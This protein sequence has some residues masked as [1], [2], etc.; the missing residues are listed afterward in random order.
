MMPSPGGTTSDC[1]Y[2]RFSGDAVSSLSSGDLQG[3]VMIRR[4]MCPSRGFAFL[5]VVLSLVLVPLGGTA[6]SQT[7]PSIKLTS[8]PN[9]VGSGARALGMGGAFIAVADDA[10]AAS[11]NPGGLPQLERPEISVVG[12]GYHRIE[13]NTFYDH[14]EASGRQWTSEAGLNYLSAV[15]P[16]TV[17][18]RNLVVSLNYQH[19][20]EFSRNWMLNFSNPRLTH[21]V[22]YQASGG[23]YAWG[24]ASAI[25]IVPQLSFGFTINFWQDG[26]YENGWELTRKNS[27]QYR[28]FGDMTWQYQSLQ[29]DRYT[30]SGLNANLGLL[31]NVT[32][33]L[34]FGAVLKTPFQAQL[35]HRF[36]WRNTAIEPFRP[37]KKRVTYLSTLTDEEL[38]MPMTYGFGLA[39]R[40]SDR[41]TVSAD[42]SRTGWHEFVLTDKDGKKF[43]PISNGPA[44]SADVDATFQ[45]RFGAEYLFI[46]PKYTIPLRA[47]IFYDPAPA[48]KSPDN[49]FGFSLGSGI[50]VGRFIFDAAYACRFG[51]NV[52]KWAD[53]GANMAQNITEHSL[54]TSLIIHF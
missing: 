24:V 28:P 13:N 5:G 4:I 7:L 32:N 38:D 43:S 12:E 8:S 20:Y 6:Q 37:D 39:Y 42:V 41:L 44:S 36:T 3:E 54:Y 15:Y 33:Q 30:F 1:R 9:P 52:G 31:W 34:T 27:T 21:T 14:P 49:Y 29:R 46:Q 35:K 47:G 53:P 11:W 18:N 48:P 26:I 19:L 45:G 23:L 16:F 40:F 25:Q 50:G 51:R 22:D 17:L 2:A 10:T